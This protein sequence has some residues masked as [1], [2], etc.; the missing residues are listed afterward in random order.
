MGAST[1]E[2]ERAQRF[3]AAIEDDRSFRAWYE[4]ALPRVYGYLF[5]R[6]GGIRSVAEEITQEAFV[7][8]VRQRG[9]FDGR[10]DEITW[11]IAIARHKLADHYRRLAREE[12]RHLKLVSSAIGDTIDDP[13]T[14][15]DRREDVLRA[16]NVLPALQR[17]AMVLHYLDQLSV[18]EIAAELD[19]SESAVESLLSRGR[20]SLRRGLSSTAGGEALDG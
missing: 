1:T 4:A 17:A 16:L 8:A 19:R 20:D 13:G 2:R 7:A 15:I 5:D 3:R 9:R 14:A 18:L 11:I 10:S 12:R 6:C